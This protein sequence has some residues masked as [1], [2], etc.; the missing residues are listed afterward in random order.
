MTDPLRA[1]GT[2]KR[3][4]VSGTNGDAVV[5]L[6]SDEEDGDKKLPAKPS[7]PRFSSD[8][9]KRKQMSTDQSHNYESTTTSVDSRS[10]SSTPFT[11]PYFNATTH[12]SPEA[13]ASPK[14]NICNSLDDNKFARVL[15]AVENESYSDAN[16]S[17]ANRVWGR[18]QRVM[19]YKT[20]EGEPPPKQIFHSRCR[21]AEPV[22]TQLPWG[23]PPLKLSKVNGT[24]N[25]TD[26]KKNGTYF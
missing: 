17:L 9:N 5:D 25:T 11:L 8:S 13:G 14:K 7:L 6:V 18:S 22:L 19:N 4:S 26:L 15:E 1:S 20:P 23:N 24:K 3:K 16:K 10:S 12:L 21:H 2:K